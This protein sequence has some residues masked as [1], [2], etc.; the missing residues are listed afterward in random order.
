MDFKPNTKLIEQNG[1]QLSMRSKSTPI[2]SNDV[3][4]IKDI[5][6]GTKDIEQL[7]QLIIKT[8]E[9]N[10]INATLRLAQFILDYSE[11]ITDDLSAI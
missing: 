2:A 4:I 3:Y 7:K 8:E 9:I 6:K 11:F 10:E 5:L 1:Y